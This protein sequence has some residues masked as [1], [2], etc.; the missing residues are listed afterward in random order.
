M[1]VRTSGSCNTANQAIIR[2]VEAQAKLCQPDQIYWCDGSESEKEILTAEA[3]AKGVL[4]KLNQE[5]LPGCYYHRSNPNDVARVEQ[6]TF[7]CTPMQDE[8][9]PTNN[10]MPPKEMYAKLRGLCD[11]SMRGRTMYVVPYLMGPLGSPLTKVG[12][13]LTDSIYVVLSM[14]IMARMGQLAYTQLGDSDD[15]NRGLHCMLDVNPDRRFIAHFPQDN[16]V[17]SVGS[18][19]GGNVLLGKKCLALRIGSYLGRNEGWMA[20]HMLIL[21][22]ES[23]ESEK[24]YVAAAFPSA[25]GKT[26]FAMLVPPA[27]FKGWKIWTVGDDIAWMKP[28]P[29]GRLYAINPEAG[30]FGVVPG[31]N[32]KSNPIAVKTIQRDTIYTNVALTPDGDVWWEGKDG[33]VPQEC[34]DWRGNKWTPDSKEKAAHANSRFAAPMTNNPMLDPNASSPEGVP[35]SAIIFGGR[36]ADTMPLIYQAFNWIHGVYVGATMGSE[37]TAAAVGGLGQVRRDP[38]AMLPF[39][40]YNMGDYF[41]HWITMRK[42][43][44]FP[45]RIFHVNWFRKDADGTFLWP[46]FGENMRVLKWIVNRCNGHANAVE[47]PL[48]WVPYAKDFDLQGLANYTPEMFDRVQNINYDDWRRELLQ[49]DELFMKIYTHLPKELIFQRELLVARL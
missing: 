31:T 13:E 2:W 6:C 23:P 40:G 3:V 14:R 15:F 28:G 19:Y 37:M 25:C 10:W 41:R 39:C 16:A 43:I 29:D 8:A 36:R 30:Y 4:V 33:P 22:V 17:I 18:N 49:Q 38:M 1:N 35:I 47:T 42:L 44:K 32:S 45:P 12:V 34:L 7:I 48:G 21:G 26:N 27:H 24:T 5:K 46:G 20:E 11:G 9:G